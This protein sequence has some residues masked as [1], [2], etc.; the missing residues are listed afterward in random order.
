MTKLKLLLILIAFT[1]LLYSCSYDSVENL[2]PAT[3]D[4]DTT[5]ISYTNDIWPIIDSNC[6]S[7]HSGNAPS[8]NVNLENYDQIKAAGINGS[9]LGVIKHES[10]WSPMPKGTSKLPD[11]D[12]MKIET[13]GNNGYPDN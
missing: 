12:I 5:N 7:C 6:T 1:F 3:G 9:L 8:G 10:G 13:W 11:C 2:Y 4:C